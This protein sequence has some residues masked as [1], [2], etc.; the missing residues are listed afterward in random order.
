[1]ISKDCCVMNILPVIIIVTLQMKGKD[2]SY[3]LSRVRGGEE[4]LR[5]LGRQNNRFNGH[6]IAVSPYVI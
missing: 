2:Q 6:P 4:W 5:T 3:L 1:M